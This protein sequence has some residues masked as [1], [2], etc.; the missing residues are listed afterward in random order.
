MQQNQKVTPNHDTLAILA[1]FNVEEAYHTYPYNIVY[2]NLKTNKHR[3]YINVYELANFINNL[4]PRNREI[5][6]MRFS[7]GCTYTNIAKLLGVTTCRISQI[8]DKICRE[9]LNN[10]RICTIFDLDETLR[11][12]DPK[13]ISVCDIGLPVRAYNALY[14]NGYRNLQDVKDLFDSGKIYKIRNIGIHTARELKDILHEYGI[15]VELKW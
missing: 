8:C 6:Y 3:A 4:T 12:S 1:I 9:I 10:K 14:R 13:D 11:L 7:R 5:I 2:S 15:N